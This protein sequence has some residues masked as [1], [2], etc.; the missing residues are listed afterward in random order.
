MST[1]ALRSNRKAIMAKMTK[2]KRKTQLT[3]CFCFHKNTEIG[4]LVTI[5]VIILSKYLKTLIQT[6]KQQCNNI[7]AIINVPS[8]KYTLSQIHMRISCR[9]VCTKKTQKGQMFARVDS[10]NDLHDK[11]STLQNAVNICCSS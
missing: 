4:S 1:R 7:L 3:N 11:C 8:K 9:H 6:Y 10:C 2:Q 5:T